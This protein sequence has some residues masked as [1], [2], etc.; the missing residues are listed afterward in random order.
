MGYIPSKVASSLRTKKNNTIAIISSMPLATSNSHSKLG[1]LF[2]IVSEI[3]HL[4]INKDYSILLTPPVTTKSK[5]HNLSDIAG[6][7]IIEP[8][9][10]DICIEFLKKQQIPFVSIGCNQNITNSNQFVDL[11][12][13]KIST[14]LINHLV[15]KQCSN[16]ALIM[17]ESS[18]LSQLEIKDDYLDKMHKYNRL[19][20][21]VYADEN[22]G[23][24]AGYNAAEYLLTHNED[25][26]GI[27][28]TID[29][30]AE[31]AL[32]YIKGQKINVPEDIK[33][34]TRF[35]GIISQTSTPPMTA[36]DLHLE[37]ASMIALEKLF[38]QIDQSKEI[39]SLIPSPV[40]IEKEST[41]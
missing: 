30:F 17:G 14:L 36:I 6:A 40:L 10:D 24:E 38:S 25:I 21:I 33:I 34:C 32:N 41:Q 26:D 29:T 12:Y 1:F 35:D 39:N 13:T 23:V 31:G 19:P 4:T 9:N 18:R 28:V 16:I 3:T 7:I 15:T 20:I 37:D 11:H 5:L 8:E 22:D 2:N 27:I